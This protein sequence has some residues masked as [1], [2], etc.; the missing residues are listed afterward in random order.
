MGA[1]TVSYERTA[2]KSLRRLPGNVAELIRSKVE[3]LA[4]DPFALNNNV[5]ALRGRDGYRLR[6]GDWRIIYRIDRG[7][8]VIWVI[9]V[10]SR[11]SIYQ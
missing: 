3:F 2:L 8:L 6:V 4:R 5:K 1:Y 11:G 9:A 10:G 7:E